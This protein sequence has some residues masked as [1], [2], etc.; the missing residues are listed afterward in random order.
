VPFLSNYSSHKDTK[1]WR[2]QTPK[3][4]KCRGQRETTLRPIKTRLQIIGY[5]R[6]RARKKRETVSMLE[7][8]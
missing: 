8:K 5:I 7:F 6:N 4:T 3:W 2:Q 1:E